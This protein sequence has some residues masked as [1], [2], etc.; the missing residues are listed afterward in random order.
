MNVFKEKRVFFTPPSSV[1]LRNRY[2]QICLTTRLDNTYKQGTLRSVLPLFPPLHSKLSNLSIIPRDNQLG[3][4][5]PDLI[6]IAH[7]WKELK[8]QM[9]ARP[10]CP[11]SESNL[12]MILLLDGGKSLQPR[13]RILWKV[14]KIGGYFSSI[15]DLQQSHIDAIFWCPHPF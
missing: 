2:K 6:P 1:D 10:C 13:A 14:L 7:V 9:R 3:R 11:P 12:L 15:F 8:H 4:Q 5:S